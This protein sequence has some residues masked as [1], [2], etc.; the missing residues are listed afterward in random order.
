MQDDQTADLRKKMRSI[1]FA[2]LSWSIEWVS[3]AVKFV[4][5]AELLV[6]NEHC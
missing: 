2:F 1:L 6:R 5:E 3:C 4:S